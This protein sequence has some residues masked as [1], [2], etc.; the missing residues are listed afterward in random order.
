[1]DA[2]SHLGCSERISMLR[3]SLLRGI[4]WERRELIPCL[5]AAWVSAVARQGGCV[6][7]WE[8]RPCRTRGWNVGGV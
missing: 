6:R 5:L 7:G 8:N 2:T 1:M 3:L 4:K